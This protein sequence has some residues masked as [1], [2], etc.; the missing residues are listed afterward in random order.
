MGAIRDLRLSDRHTKFVFYAA[1]NAGL[2]YGIINALHGENP[3]PL[4][5]SYLTDEYPAVA[6]VNE[7]KYFEVT[8]Y[9]GH[10][11]SVDGSA[12]REEVEK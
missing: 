12:R 11:E 5:R 9:C 8:D 6:Q 1:T 7:V 2:F 3:E 10:I 4:V